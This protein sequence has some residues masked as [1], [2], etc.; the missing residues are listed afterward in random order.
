VRIGENLYATMK[1]LGSPKVVPVACWSRYD[2][3]SVVESA[4]FDSPPNQLNGFWLSFQP[5]WLHLAPKQCS[6]IQALIGTRL[7]NGQRA[8][9]LTTALH[10]R[11][12]ADGFRNEAQTECYAIQLVYEFAR[13]LGF[14]YPR[15]LRLVQL[16]G[17]KSRAVFAGTKYYDPIRC[18]D[19]GKW[20]LYPTF[21]NLR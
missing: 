13:E 2:W 19:G 5:R 9:A 20:D 7:P 12:H 10:E 17:R 18:R 21:T 14:A 11:I 4:G 16:A 1:K 3:P 6:D 15:A 8:Y